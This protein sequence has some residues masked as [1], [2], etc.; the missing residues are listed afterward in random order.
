MRCK[1][2]SIVAGLLVAGAVTGYSDEAREDYV[3][4]D[5][6]MTESAVP[7]GMANW[8]VEVGM[9][10]TKAPDNQRGKYTDSWS[11]EAR[12]DGRSLRMY[13]WQLE[14]TY[15]ITPDTDLSVTSGYVEIKDELEAVGEEY[16]RGPDSLNVSLKHR[17]METGGVSVA[18]IPGLTFPTGRRSY[19]TEERFGPGQHYL[20]FD[21]RLAMT[22]DFD[23]LAVNADLGYSLPFGRERESY[24]REWGEYTPDDGTEVG[25]ADA[26]VGVIYNEGPIRPLLEVTYAHRFVSSESDRTLM[27]ATFGSVVTLDERFRVKI[28]YQHPVAGR[29]AARMRRFLL[30]TAFAF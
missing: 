7:V 23:I 11:R 26:N 8:D 9:T 10:Y 29:H 6:L 24:E 13:E 12:G 15:G 16:G 30:S 25:A 22:Q 14:L 2:I 4:G 27:H 3:R 18:Y 1:L 28:G 17:F 19:T 5:T 20:S 21:Q